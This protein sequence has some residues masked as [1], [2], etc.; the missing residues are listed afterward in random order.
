[1]IREV[2]PHAIVEIAPASE[3]VAGAG[4]DEHVKPLPRAHEGVRDHHAVMQ[5]QGYGSNAYLLNWYQD[6]VSDTYPQA[7]LLSVPLMFYRLLMLAWALWLAFSLLK[8][9]KWGWLGFSKGGLWRSIEFKVPKVRMGRK[10][11]AA[12]REDLTLGE[13]PVRE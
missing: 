9:L 2:V 8:W 10:K 13:I 5:V 12:E 7:T 11:A 6:R 3:T 4:D 1:M